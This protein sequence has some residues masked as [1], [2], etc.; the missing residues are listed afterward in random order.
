[1]PTPASPL[2][3]YATMSYTQ[4]AELQKQRLDA[5]DNTPD[6]AELLNLYHHFKKV[7]DTG[8]YDTD[9]T[10]L[11]NL[12]RIKLWGLSE[13]LTTSRL[14]ISLAY[15]M[16]IHVAPCGLSAAIRQAMTPT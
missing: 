2:V 5:V 13:Y 15:Q 9:F 12:H 6:P 3:N 8:D 4:I 11:A 7:R 1:M 10:S 16:G 14:K